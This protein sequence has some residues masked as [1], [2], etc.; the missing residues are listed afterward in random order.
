MPETDLGTIHERTDV[1]TK[2]L[3]LPNEKNLRNVIAG[4]TP[5]NPSIN[6]KETKQWT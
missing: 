4:E 1:L 3:L 6:A 2:N 5:E